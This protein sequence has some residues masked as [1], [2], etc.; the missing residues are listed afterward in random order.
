MIKLFL[1]AIILSILTFV[2]VNAQD[3]TNADFKYLCSNQTITGLS[4]QATPYSNVKA[5]CQSVALTPKIDFYLIRIKSGSTFTFSLTPNSNIDFDFVSWLNP[6]LKNVGLGDRGSSN[7]PHLLRV[8]SIGLDLNE[9]KVCDPSG[10][11]SSGKVRYYNVQPG[12]IVLLAID[13]WEDIDS[14]YTISFGGDATL[15]CSFTGNEFSVC[16]NNN[17]GTFDLNQ[18][19]QNSMSKYPAN[20]TGKF[21]LNKADAIGDNTN[22]INDNQL[23]LNKADLPKNIFLQIKN[24]LNI[25]TRVEEISLK[26]LEKLNF[27]PNDLTYCDYLSS[28]DID[29]SKSI[30]STL[31]PNNKFKFRYFTS[32]LDAENVTNEITDYLHYKGVTNDIYIRTESIENSECFT[33]NHFKILN[34]IDAVKSME[35]INF[36]ENKT[37]PLLINLTEIKAKK[38][39]LND[40][41]IDYYLTLNDLENNRKIQNPTDFISSSKDGF[42]YIKG[43]KNNSC[44]VFYK[45]DYHIE[46]LDLIGLKDI[47]T[48]CEGDAVVVD[49][50]T[51]ID[52]IEVLQPHKIIAYNVFE[53][54]NPGDYEFKI[55]NDLGCSYNYK[56]T[57]V[58]NQSPIMKSIDISS[59]KVIFTVTH[60]READIYYSLDKINWQKNKE[61][62][63]TK[64]GEKYT[65]YAKLDECIFNIY[66]FENYNF[67][68]FLSPNQD[69]KNDN[70]SINFS[71]EIKA[72]SVSIFDLFGKVIKKIDAPTPVI[73]DGK[74]NGLALPTDTYW[75]KIE[76]LQNIEDAPLKIYSGSV[77]LK[78]K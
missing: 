9:T 72:Y 26:I 19:K 42:I 13:R 64:L 61:F 15:D 20:Y 60:P 65:I 11:A 66:T 1:Y 52:K 50:S 4:P 5:N 77:L 73:W 22:T 58:D 53:L 44:P 40:Y 45:I 69:G 31:L 34:R 56:T 59:D 57:V 54:T 63:L 33:I 24:E 67:P 30:P 2:H 76:I 23:V 51:N 71:D 17:Q 39:I 12:D 28:T 10:A 14:G 8:Y 70:W 18:I 37:N 47:Y 48:K 16:E 6:D 62:K 78:R 38:A 75:Y 36:C 21:Y 41:T 46:S 29:L 68:N 55:T 74:Q 49:L 3:L 32:Q 27:T 7:N 25:L 43:N 35:T